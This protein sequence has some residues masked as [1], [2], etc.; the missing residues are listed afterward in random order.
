MSRQ[1]RGLSW[2]RHHVFSDCLELDAGGSSHVMSHLM[3]TQSIIK[4]LPSFE[5]SPSSGVMKM[6]FITQRR[7]S[8]D[9]AFFSLWL[10][11]FGR[12]LWA[13]SGTEFD[14]FCNFQST[15]HSGRPSEG[16]GWETG[17]AS[18]FALSLLRT[19]CAAEKP[20]L[21]MLTYNCVQQ[22]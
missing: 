11:I 1:T 16:G 9:D 7:V 22:N 20:N 17:W 13:I 12:I 18:D 3:T 4:S 10:I 14:V 2:D 6:I 19:C 21:G 15:P 8:E 5:F